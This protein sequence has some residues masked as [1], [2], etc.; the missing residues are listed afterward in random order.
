M[1]QG[2]VKLM[3]YCQKDYNF[4]CLEIDTDRKQFQEMAIRR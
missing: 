4:L 3:S 1:G 2:V